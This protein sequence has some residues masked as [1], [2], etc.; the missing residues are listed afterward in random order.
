MVIIV[1]GAPWVGISLPIL[2]LVLWQIQKFYLKTSRQLRY[3]ELE[4]KAP[5]YTHFFE[6]LDGIHS[7]RA[8]GWKARF[9]KQNIEL[10]KASQKP[11]YLLT[12]IQIWLMFVLDCVVVALVLAV[13]CIVV[14]LRSSASVGLIGLALFNLVCVQ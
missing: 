4:A 3:M 13:A 1:V 10:L 5:L 8:F 7:I 9:R 11:L 6:T 14:T 12:A 2:I